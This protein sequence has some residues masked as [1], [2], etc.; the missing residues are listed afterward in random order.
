MSGLLRR[1]LFG[2]PSTIAGTVYGTIIVMA[3]LTAGGPAFDDR[4]WELVVVVS[5]TALVFWLAHVYAHG[6]GE[7]IA[8]GRRLDLAELGAIAR[9]EVTILLAAVLPVLALFLG[10]L[11]IVR[12]SSAVWLAM[13]V[14]TATLAAQGVRYARVERLSRGGEALTIAVNLGLGLV[15]VVLKVLVQH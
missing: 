6:L 13:G 3:A 12:H 8:L 2:S 14:A 11:G 7:S 15:I 10:A 4:P 1:L 9:R 5:V